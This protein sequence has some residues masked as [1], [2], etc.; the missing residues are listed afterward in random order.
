MEEGTKNKKTI[1]I[2]GLNEDIDQTTLISTFST[3]GDI[4]DVQIPTA[5]PNNREEAVRSRGFAFVT[6]STQIDAQDAIDNMDLNEFNGRVIRVNLAR[7]QK[8]VLANGGYGRA[9]WESEEWLQ[10]H[11]RPVGSGGV[12]SQNPGN[13]KQ[14]G[15]AVPDEGEGADAEGAME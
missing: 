7:P 1:F 10:E 14:E 6:Y 13:T 3:F 12:G 2:G 8:G 11:A 4:I 15:S 9:I 5:A